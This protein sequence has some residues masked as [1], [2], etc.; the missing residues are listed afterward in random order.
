M[1]TA[2][3]PLLLDELARPLRELRV[4]VT[5]RCNLRC[6]YCMPKSVFGPDHAFLPRGELLSP[7]ELAQVVR[8]FVA[9]GVRKV[10]ITGGEPQARGDLLYIVRALRG[11]DGIEDLAMI[12]NGIGLDERKAQALREAGLD[13][14]TI[15]LDALDDARFRHINGMGV[16]VAKVLS[17]IEAAAQAGFTP[18]KINV[19]VRR[20][21]NDADVLPIARH[22]HGSGHIVRFIEYMDV[23][24]S[25]GWRLDDVVPAQE[26]IERID[27]ELPLQA[28][29]ANRR[30]EVAKRWRYRDGGGEIGVISAVTQ[31]FCQDCNR[32]RLSADGRMYNCL[33]AADGLDLRTPL[34]AGDGADIKAMIRGY[35]TNRSERYSEQRSEHA[36]TRIAPTIPVREM[37]PVREQRVE[38]SYIGG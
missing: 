32:A 27:A 15:S 35:W 1:T 25:N 7:H 8:E 12:S 34:R 36:E 11:I 28:L 23:G 3:K 21:A 29:D 20:G 14:L 31:P 19:V 9:L 24:N 10:R 13:R 38:M 37:R 16:P 6:T 30:G 26:I 2:P 17:G 18:L 4:S 33:F 5:D 22:F